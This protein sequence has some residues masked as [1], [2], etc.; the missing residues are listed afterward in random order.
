MKVTFYHPESSKR[1][2]YDVKEGQNVE[3]IKEIVENHLKIDTS[4][5]LLIEK[6]I[7]LYYGVCELKDEWIFTDLIIPIGSSIKCLVKNHA[8]ADFYCFIKFKNE[9]LELYDTNFD[10]NENIVLELRIYISN[11]IGLPL[12]VFRLKTAQNLDMYDSKKLSDYKISTKKNEILLETWKNWDT[13]LRYCIQGS[14]IKVFSLMSPNKAIKQFQTRVAL[15]IAAHYGNLDLINNLTAITVRL[16]RPVGEHPC[17]EWCYDFNPNKS[18]K[19]NYLKL[20]YLKCPIHVIILRGKLSVLISVLKNRLHL[21]EQKDPY[22]LL[23]WRLA[24]KNVNNNKKLKDMAS[25]LILK[26]FS[27]KVKL[28]RNLK[29]SIRLYAKIKLWIENSKEHV[30][31]IY[32]SSKSSI[33]SSAFFIKPGLIGNVPLIDGYNNDFKDQTSFNERLKYYS[34]NHHNLS[35]ISTFNNS[36]KEEDIIPPIIKFN[37]SLEETNLKLEFYNMKSADQLFNVE[38][39]IKFPI[40][41]KIHYETMQMYEKYRNG[42]SSEDTVKQVFKDVSTFRSKTCIQKIQMGSLM[43]QKITKRRFNNIDL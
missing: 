23:P 4:N 22:G 28:S 19:L 35:V 10:P 18:D 17:R 26:K 3:H 12:S 8:I 6:K 16:D 33:K 25:Y 36:I 32:G 15:Y 14:S 34:K 24:L 43:L 30:F 29:I 31:H 40:K 27:G 41:N 20:E 2:M 37:R 11:L 13:F 7:H 21:L 9:T 38:R 1:F 39:K 5:T 42:E